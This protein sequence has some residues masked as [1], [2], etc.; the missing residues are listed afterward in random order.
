PPPAPT[1]LPY[2]T[3]FRSRRRRHDRGVGRPRTLREACEPQR[4]ESGVAHP[5]RPEDP[6]LEE[7]VERLARDAL[8]DLAK[9]DRAEIAVDGLRSE[10]HTSELQSRENLV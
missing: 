1:L 9:E 5:E 2:T 3:L 4:V 8:D 6:A 10:E 7:A